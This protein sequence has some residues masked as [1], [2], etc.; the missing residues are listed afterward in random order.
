MYP[1]KR[2]RATAALVMLSACCLAACAS[3]DIPAG[4]SF[5]YNGNSWNVSDIRSESRLVIVA[6]NP[7]LD[8]MGTEAA[9]RHSVD[10]MP[11]AEYRAAAA[12]WLSTTGRFCA[13]GTGQDAEPGFQ[14][15]YS[16]WTPP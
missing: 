16:C 11:E 12:G 4:Q 3:D 5:T 15:N 7:R 8:G 10:S 6:V 2:L 1:A 14:Y 9:V 13:P